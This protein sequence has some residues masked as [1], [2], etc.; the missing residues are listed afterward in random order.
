MTLHIVTNALCVAFVGATMLG[1]QRVSLGLL[2]VL[3]G[4]VMIW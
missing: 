1:L 2:G 4:V 3:L